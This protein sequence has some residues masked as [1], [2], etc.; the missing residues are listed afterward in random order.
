MRGRPTGRPGQNSER[1]RALVDTVT[2]LGNVGQRWPTLGPIFV[3]IGGASN[4]GPN[5]SPKNAS[6]LRTLE[7]ASAG[8]AAGLLHPG[9]ADFPQHPVH[10]MCRSS[11][12]TSGFLG[13]RQVTSGNAVFSA[14][15]PAYICS[16][17]AEPPDAITHP[18]PGSCAEYFKSGHHTLGHRHDLHVAQ[19]CRVAWY[20]GEHGLDEHIRAA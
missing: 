18:T 20:C 17:A 8:L 14:Q 15:P 4:W 3:F 11:N 12:T 9:A 13:I 16:I 10:D 1:S 6:T 19:A 2:G 5:V 7:A